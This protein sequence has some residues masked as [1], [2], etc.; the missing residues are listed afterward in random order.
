M[1]A[2]RITG[3]RRTLITGT[4]PSERR[5]N[6]EVTAS[7]WIDPEY[8]AFDSATGLMDIDDLRRNIG[9]DVSAVYVEVPSYLGGIEP[10]VSR[11]AEIAHG[12]GALLIVGV[13]AI[14]LGVLAAP[15]DYGADIVVGEAQ[16]LGVHMMYSGG[17]CGFIAS[18]DEPR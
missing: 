12:A 4:L 7:K 14:S 15:A 1:M 3:R 11:I 2:A 9:D 6:I 13:D 18:R 8:I 16:A 10:D 5:S 17:L